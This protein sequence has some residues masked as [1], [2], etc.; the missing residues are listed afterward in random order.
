VFR[1]HAIH[2]AKSGNVVFCEGKGLM[3]YDARSTEGSGGWGRWSARRVT[4]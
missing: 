3:W 1:G 4:G 2:A